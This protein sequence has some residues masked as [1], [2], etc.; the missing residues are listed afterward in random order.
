MKFFKDSEGLSLALLD[1]KLASG[2]YGLDVLHEDRKKEGEDSKKKKNVQQQKKIEREI[3]PQIF[4]DH[5]MLSERVRKSCYYGKLPPTDRPSLAL[6]Q[7]AV[8]QFS[9][10]G[11]HKLSRLDIARASEMS[12]DACA[13]PTSLVFALIYLDRLRRCAPDYLASVS[14]ADLFLV[15]MMVASKFLYDDG[16]EDEVF[17]DEWAKSGQMDVKDFNR[18]EVDFL[19]AIDWNVNVPQP[20]FESALQRI[21]RQ[22][23]YR[24]LTRR[25]FSTYSDLDVLSNTE[26]VAGLWKL[27]ADA[28]MRVTTVCMAAYAASLFTLLGSTALLNQATP[29]G[30]DGVA[31]SYRT[32]TGGGAGGRN[33][34][35]RQSVVDDLSVANTGNHGQPLPPQYHDMDFDIATA[36]TAANFSEILQATADDSHFADVVGG[37]QQQQPRVSTAELLTASF[38]V[39]SIKSEDRFNSGD[40]GGSRRERGGGTLAWDIDRGWDS[41]NTNPHHHYDDF[42]DIQT[43]NGT[44]DDLTA[45]STTLTVVPGWLLH[46]TEFIHHATE[47]NEYEQET[48][49]GEETDKSILNSILD[50]ILRRGA[51][52]PGDT[53]SDYKGATTR[54]SSRDIMNDNDDKRQERRVPDLHSSSPSDV[55]KDD[56]FWSH[57]HA[58]RD[59]F[60]IE[61]HDEEA[62]VRSL[63]LEWSNSVLWNHLPGIL[64][65]NTE[66]GAK[67]SNRNGAKITQQR[68]P[69]QCPLR[70][71][72]RGNYHHPITMMHQIPI[73]V[74]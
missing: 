59:L 6:T 25:H 74:L 38:L 51:E 61:D 15:S 29:F 43:N 10:V 72:L 68:K 20:E 71:L 7:L 67:T 73:S 60:D 48:G 49:G 31:R 44:Q 64:R 16:E 34:G 39:A 33:D 11:I 3:S 30:P 2:L 47:H 12:R 66:N 8:E 56:D 18:L 19:A 24:E 52:T 40:S 55:L 36:T 50:L 45:S 14:S 13:S 27:L 42:D 1:I 28:A 62:Q 5:D 65:T 23:A 70:N 63:A 9:M 26:G 57:F 41:F 22:I 69:A 32:L 58:R 54:K 46:K 35:R 37:R 21:E 17:N 4:P 53:N